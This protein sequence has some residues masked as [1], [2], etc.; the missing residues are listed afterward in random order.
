MALDSP[1]LRNN[2]TTPRRQH[3]H[4]GNCVRVHDE[5]LIFNVYKSMHPSRDSKS[6]MKLGMDDQASSEPPDISSFTSTLC[7]PPIEDTTIKKAREAHKKEDKGRKGKQEYSDK[8]PQ[9]YQAS[10]TQHSF[11][12]WVTMKQGH[13]TEDVSSRF[14]DPP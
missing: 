10:T 11:L 1:E 12:T 5:C 6:C 14:F 8:F 4:L 7:K 2:N 13:N 9:S 3:Q